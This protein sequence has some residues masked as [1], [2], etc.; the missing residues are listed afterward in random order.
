LKIKCR[1]R[2]IGTTYS[3]YLWKTGRKWKAGR[4]VACVVFIPITVL[5][6]VIGSCIVFLRHKRRKER[7]NANSDQQFL[8]RPN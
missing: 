4:K 3:F 6:I 2:A 7:G 5:A 8:Y 1:L